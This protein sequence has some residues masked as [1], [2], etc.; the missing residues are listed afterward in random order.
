MKQFE[1]QFTVTFRWQRA[2]GKPIRKIHTDA[3]EEA[4]IDRIF[5]MWTNGFTSGELSDCITMDSRDPKDGQD[6]SGW[7]ELKETQP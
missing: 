3:L 4:A 1:K 6:Y 2:D 7:W 5:S